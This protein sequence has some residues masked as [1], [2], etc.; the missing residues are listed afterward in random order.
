MP[1]FE[2]TY[3][4]PHLAGQ[5]RFKYTPHFPSSA[6]LNA[7]FL[8]SPITSRDW[9]AAEQAFELA[10]SDFPLTYCSI[11]L[12]EKTPLGLDLVQRLAKG[13]YDWAT[14]V[15]MQ[16]TDPW[17]LLSLN[18]QA[19]CQF[20]Q[21]K[22]ADW[23]ALLAFQREFDQ[24]YGQIYLDEHARYLAH[25]LKQT[26][27]KAYGI[28]VNHV[29]VSS[30]LTYDLGSYL[31]IDLLSTSSSYQKQGYC[32]QLLAN[33]ATQSNKDHQQ[34]LLQADA[35]S[36][37]PDMYESYGFKEVSYRHHVTKLRAKNA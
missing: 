18:A 14:Y 7:L 24:A 4:S 3:H 27:V 6:Q 36:F 17:R 35:D 11:F 1:S 37:L 9:P 15:L 30:C 2:N 21:L 29:L 33:L 31:E 28:Y 22:Q 5:A 32:R 19:N 34:L 16:L 20:R 12:A 26:D 8:A 10:S 23:P 13:D 25:L